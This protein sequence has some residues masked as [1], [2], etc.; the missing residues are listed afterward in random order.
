MITKEH[1]RTGYLILLLLFLNISLFPVRMSKDKTVE[2]Q[3]TTTVHFLAPLGNSS[4]NVLI[5]ELI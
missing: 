3:T 4:P 5:M 1:Y 2:D